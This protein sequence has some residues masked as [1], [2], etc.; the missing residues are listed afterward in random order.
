M[1][2]ILIQKYL[3]AALFMPTFIQILIYFP[4][5]LLPKIFR[6]AD[7]TFHSHFVYTT[8]AERI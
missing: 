5:T 7:M 4:P 1:I 3:L 2:Q 8:T 6:V